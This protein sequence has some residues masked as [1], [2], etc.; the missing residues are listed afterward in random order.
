MAQFH[1]EDLLIITKTY[2]SPSRKYRETS[3]IAALNQNGEMRRLFPIPY[4]LL[5]GEHQFNRWEWINAQI[6]KATDDHRPE[7]YKVD[8]DSIKRITKLG[9]AQAWAERLQRI[10]P[11][12]L[13]DFTALETRRQMTGETLGFFRP[14]K[15]L[16]KIKK[17]VKPD[18]SNEEK[19]ILIQDGLFDATVVKSRVPLRKVPYDFYYSYECPTPMGY[20]EY[21]HKITDWEASALY[22]KCEK[23][24]G[25]KW[26]EYFRQKLEDDFSQNKDLI[27]LMGTMHRFPDRW[28]IVGLVYPP[29][30]TA[31]QEVFLLPPNE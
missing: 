30:V 7:S 21:K 11:H 6:I 19:L 2:P 13:P 29:R 10:E 24:Y 3:C 14:S 17:A 16:L 15:F 25:D 31:R 27:F 12:I 22:W 5:D 9:T 28:L 4:R 1:E 8:I 26:E 18:W 20:S 23:N